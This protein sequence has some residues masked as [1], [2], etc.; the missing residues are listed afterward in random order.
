MADMEHL[1]GLGPV[2]QGQQQSE[3]L[4]ILKTECDAFRLQGIA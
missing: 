2:A 1:V 4:D 3:I